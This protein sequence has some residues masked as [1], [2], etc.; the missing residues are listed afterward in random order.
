MYSKTAVR[1]AGSVAPYPGCPA[2][3]VNTTHADVRTVVSMTVRWWPSSRSRR[4]R[5]DCSTLPTR[6]SAKAICG[7]TGRRLQGSDGGLVADRAIVSRGGSQYPNKG[8]VYDLDMLS[9]C[10]ARWDIDLR[11]AEWVPAYS[12]GERGLLAVARSSLTLN[13]STSNVPGGGV[14]GGREEG[15]ESGAVGAMTTGLTTAG[16]RPQE[17]KAAMVSSWC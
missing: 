1:A 11:R 10:P 12:S 13:I 17:R 6:C 5:D 3:R 2:D 4:H 9:P 15:R 8:P 16:K 7:M 14:G